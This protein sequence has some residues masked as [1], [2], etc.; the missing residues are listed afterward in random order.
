M[1]RSEEAFNIR[2][3]MEDEWYVL[4]LIPY[5]TDFKLATQFFVNG[6]RMEVFPFI[7]LPALIFLQQRLWRWKKTRKL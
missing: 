4:F 5:Q 3:I 7:Y 2:H 1:E 6:N